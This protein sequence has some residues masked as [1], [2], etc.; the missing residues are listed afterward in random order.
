MKQYEYEG[1]YT[2]NGFAPRKVDM[3]F[4]ENG[5]YFLI[6]SKNNTALMYNVSLNGKIYRDP[7][8]RACF[9]QTILTHNCPILGRS[10]TTYS[11]CRQAH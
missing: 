2:E 11:K 6:G 4:D 7:I 9:D 3:S 10:F 1:Y 8:W 5:K